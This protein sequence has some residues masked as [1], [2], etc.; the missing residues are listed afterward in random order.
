MWG[1]NASPLNAGNA[2][3]LSS[4]A[5]TGLDWGGLVA[6]NCR[7]KPATRI[8]MVLDGLGHPR[9]KTVRSKTPWMRSTSDRGLSP[10]Q[11]DQDPRYSHIAE[12]TL[13]T[14]SRPSLSGSWTFEAALGPTLLLHFPLRPRPWYPGPV[15]PT[16][17]HSASACAPFPVAP[18]SRDAPRLSLPRFFSTWPSPLRTNPLLSSSPL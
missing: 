13:A 1:N 8:S 14:G 9:L 2:H 4:K 16:R 7:S 17:H 11:T 15:A 6:L 18:G 3:T 10:H 5:S 12:P